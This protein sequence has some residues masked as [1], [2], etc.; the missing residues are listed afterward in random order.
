VDKR[1]YERRSNELLAAYEAAKR[2]HEQNPVPEQRSKALKELRTVY[3]REQHALTAEY[4]ATNLP[5]R[6]EES[7]E[8]STESDSRGWAHWIPIIIM[9]AIAVGAR[10]CPNILERD[11]PQQEVPVE[12]LPQEERR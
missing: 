11:N 10:A 9:V 6:T 1:E 5:E 7:P 4:E 8:Y 12:T 2:S 3:K